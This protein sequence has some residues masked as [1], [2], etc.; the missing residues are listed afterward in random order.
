[1]EAALNP[2]RFACLCEPDPAAVAVE[3]TIHR[4]F[5]CEFHDIDVTVVDELE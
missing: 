5:P 4:F 2:E 3:A 1:V